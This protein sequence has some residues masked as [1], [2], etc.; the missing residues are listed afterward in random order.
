MI[1]LGIAIGVLV[2]ALLLWPRLV[3]ARRDLDHE[4]RLGEERL[5]MA[6]EQLD[7][8]VKA[9]SADALRANSEQLV[10]LARQT[11][12]ASQAEARADLE[13]R[14][15]AVEQLVAP[16]RDSLTKVDEQ[17]RRADRDRAAG[18][19][20]LH[21]QIRAMVDGQE[22]LRGETGALVAALRKPQTRGRW[23]EMHLRNVVEMA[24]MVAHCDFV[25][26][27]SIAGDQGLLRPDLIVRLP[28]DKQLVVDAKA[29]L[30]AFLDAYQATDDEARARLM[31]D[32]ARLLRERIRTLGSKAYW[33]QLDGSPD[34]VFLYLPGEHLLNAALD[35][36]PTLID[37]GVQQRVLLATPSTL[38]ALL[39]TAAYGWQ[40]ERVAEDARLIA[41]QGR[42]LYTRLA[43]MGGYVQTLGKRLNSAV[44]AF[45]ATVGSLE[46][47]VLP[48]ARRMAEHMPVPAGKEIPS[49]EPVDVTA[50]PVQAPELVDSVTVRPGIAPAEHDAA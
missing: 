3:A 31:A 25:E 43:T 45:N 33:S 38:I 4:R 39:R 50:R 37:Q 17:L 23:G 40:Q 6:Q 20:A 49:L 35:V 15:H 9:L 13:K 2:A 7:D 44:D 16:L 22:R 5:R 14:Q 24:G 12:G 42:D 1:L 48:G 27:S 10:A 46:T 36:D 30:Q 11:L 47:R 29:P 8:H 32:H 19:S 34:F 18:Q 21:A 28:G 41:E 26:Q